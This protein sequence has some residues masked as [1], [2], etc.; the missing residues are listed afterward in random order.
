MASRP[1]SGENFNVSTNSFCLPKLKMHSRPQAQAQLQEPDANPSENT[2][3]SEP[4][5]VTCPFEHPQTE[6]AAPWFASVL[7]TSSQVK[8]EETAKRLQ[9]G[10]CKRPSYPARPRGGSSGSTS[11]PSRPSSPCSSCRAPM[12]LP[13][14]LCPV[15]FQQSAP[16]ARH[17]RASAMPPA[18]KSCEVEALS[19]TVCPSQ[20]PWHIV[21]KE[22]G[23]GCM[24]C[25]SLLEQAVHHLSE[26][27]TGISQHK[28]TV[29]SLPRACYD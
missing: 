25:A 17:Q 10:V 27:L 21:S 29:C 23:Q 4:C 5:R 19:P 26:G 11:R 24:P 20:A 3:S 7:L 14:S 1:L 18:Q 16:S 13:L 15:F 22:P 28:C 2:G 8:L 9:D 12:L 6:Q